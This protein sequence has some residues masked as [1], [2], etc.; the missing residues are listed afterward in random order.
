MFKFQLSMAVPAKMFDNYLY[1]SSTSKQFRDH[2]SGIA[3]ELNNDLNL[4]KN[5]LLV[6]RSNDGI[7]LDQ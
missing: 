3:N 4:N 2:F 1:L 7:F 5:S 6:D